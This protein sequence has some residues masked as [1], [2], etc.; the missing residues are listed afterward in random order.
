MPRYADGGVLFEKNPV[1]KITF[2]SDPNNPYAYDNLTSDEL[3][4][5]EEEL[6]SSNGRFYLPSASWTD[7]DWNTFYKLVV[8]N[9]A[10]YLAVKTGYADNL[11][12][13]YLFK[14]LE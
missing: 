14:K 8:V 4:P 9:G 2:I 1:L 11:W 12:Y 13:G 5:W 3:A 7:G 10:E 6:K